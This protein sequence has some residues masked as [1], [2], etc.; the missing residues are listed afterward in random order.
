MRRSLVVYAVVDNGKLLQAEGGRP[1]PQIGQSLLGEWD[2][3]LERAQGAGYFLIAT[4]QIVAH[5]MRNEVM[6]LGSGFLLYSPD[7]FDP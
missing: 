4:T 1:P 3:G 7:G 2:Q 5:H 6:N